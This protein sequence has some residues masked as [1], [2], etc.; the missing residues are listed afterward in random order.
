[1]PLNVASRPA[2]SIVGV[3]AI[4]PGRASVVVRLCLSEAL[5][6]R[7]SLHPRRCA[8]PTRK[9]GCRQI[10]PC[11]HCCCSSTTTTACWYH[12]LRVT[13]IAGPSSR[14]SLCRGTWSSR[15]AG[16]TPLVLVALVGGDQPAVTPEELQAHL[17]SRFRVSVGTAGVCAWLGGPFARE[18]RQDGLSSVAM[19]G[20]GQAV[21]PELELAVDHYSKVQCWDFDPMLVEVDACL[22]KPQAGLTR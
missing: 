8:A 1:L 17:S 13:L 4:R 3:L 12:H 2:V 7:A 15:R 10:V 21:H 22:A 18:C 16:R 14:S 19:Q 11:H 5:R 9:N 20:G 6:R